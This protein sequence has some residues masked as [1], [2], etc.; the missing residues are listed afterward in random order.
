[1][2]LLAKFHIEMSENINVLIRVRPLIDNEKGD[3]TCVNISNNHI[4]LK[5]QTDNQLLDQYAT[6][7][8][9]NFD[10]VCGPDST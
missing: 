9:F 10:R 3:W 6:E 1:M 7:Y 8:S 2:L 4:R 5:E